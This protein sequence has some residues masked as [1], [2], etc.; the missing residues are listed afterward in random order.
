MKLIDLVQLA[1]KLGAEPDQIYLILALIES[2]AIDTPFFIG[3]S[4]EAVVATTLSVLRIAEELFYSRHLNEYEPNGFLEFLQ[5]RREFSFD[6]KDL[7]DLLTKI[8]K[9]GEDN[10][11]FNETR[12]HRSTL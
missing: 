10:Y 7:K 11:G 12:K 8:E 3:L 1:Y 6:S 2:D 5:K 9:Q 4:G